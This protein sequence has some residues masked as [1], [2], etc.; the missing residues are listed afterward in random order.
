[1]M[2]KLNAGQV[3]DMMIYV[4]DK[5]VEAKPMLT[6]VDSAIGDG[7]HGIGMELGFTKARDVLNDLNGEYTVNDVF[8]KAGKAMTSSMGGASGIIFGTMFSGGTKSMET[9]PEISTEEF[10]HTFN[11][12]L[13]AIKKRGGAN[14]GD[15]TMVDA[16]E[17]AVLAM[18][19]N[20]GMEF[21]EFLGK[22]AEAAKQGM[23]NTK[24]YQAKF[25]RA[26]SLMQRAIGFQDAGAT[27]VYIIFKAM[28]QCLKEMEAV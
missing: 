8:E 3:K 27:S 22:A 18:Q 21:K 10:Y 1:M 15:K 24:N 14:V 4:A 9:M 2:K 7:D 25:G 26:K 13:L 5:I 28:Y 12:A 23:N 20:I 6:K 16:L 17:P 11:N 19:N